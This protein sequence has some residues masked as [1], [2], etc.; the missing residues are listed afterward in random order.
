M[1]DK[2]ELIELAPGPNEP[3]V[4]SVPPAAFPLRAAPQPSQFIIDPLWG[5]GRLYGEWTP[6]ATIDGSDP[7]CVWVSNV[8]R[9]VV[10]LLSHPDVFGDD[11]TEYLADALEDVRIPRALAA[12][13]VVT[14]RAAARR[15]RR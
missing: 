12:Y 9:G 1:R 14:V 10:V 7:P 5:G 6:P 8:G 2:K 13:Y 3:P 15:N 4:L 11:F